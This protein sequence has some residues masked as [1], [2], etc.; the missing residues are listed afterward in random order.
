[1]ARKL[2]IPFSQASDTPIEEIADEQA[3]AAGTAA[4]DLQPAPSAAACSGCCARVEQTAWSVRD[5]LS[6]DTWRTIH[7]LT[8]SEGLPAAGRA[9]RRRRPRASIWTRWCAA[10]PPCRACRP[11][12]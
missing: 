10:P 3:L 7:A 8:A 11:R 4:A 9:F 2:L 5:R 1:M 6:L 12:T